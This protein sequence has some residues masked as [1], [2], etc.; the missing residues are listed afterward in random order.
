MAKN[1]LRLQIITPTR[2]VLDSEVDS[3][4]LRTAEGDMG[5]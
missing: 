1:K 4:V 5:V 2:S 3:V